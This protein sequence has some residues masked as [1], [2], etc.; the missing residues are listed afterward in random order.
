MAGN[1][2]LVG[3][4]IEQPF[5]TPAEL[6]AAYHEL[7]RSIRAGEIMPP[8]PDPAPPVIKRVLPDREILTAMTGLG[9]ILTVRLM[10]AAAVGGAFLLAYQ[11]MQSPSLMAIEV[12]VA[13]AVTTVAPLTFL[14]TKRT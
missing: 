10:L 7:E 9:A 2:K 11:A 6:A 5:V 8:L 12:L 1:V 3:E 14:S 4:E 13:Y